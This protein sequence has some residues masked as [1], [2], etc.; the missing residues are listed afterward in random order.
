[1]LK[2]ELLKCYPTF[3]LLTS[4]VTKHSLE[5]YPYITGQDRLR[6]RIAKE[7]LSIACLDT[8]KKTIDF[9]DIESFDMW[10][11]F[12]ADYLGA[13]ITNAVLP[14]MHVNSTSDFAASICMA[15]AST[16]RTR[17]CE[18]QGR[19]KKLL[20]NYTDA[21][22]FSSLFDEYGLLH[23]FLVKCV[24]REVFHPE[25]TFYQ[26]NQ[27]DPVTNADCLRKITYLYE[28]MRDI[29]RELERV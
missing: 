25:S 5:T 20:F 17:V 6:V 28:D 19:A 24:A 13:D 16:E 7:L 18:V 10:E 3:W 11:M 29:K 22:E 9:M 27:I 15:N 23:S 14:R 8:Y 4:L 1:M 26:H 12:K 21:P 2:T